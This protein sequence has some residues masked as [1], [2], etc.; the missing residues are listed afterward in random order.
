VRTI[1]RG[2]IGPALIVAALQFVVEIV[3]PIPWIGQPFRQQFTVGFV[4]MM[5]SQTT[6]LIGAAAYAGFLR[7]RSRASLSGCAVGGAAVGLLANFASQAAKSVLLGLGVIIMMDGAAT[8]V[9]LFV[10]FLSCLLAGVGG[11]VLGEVGGGVVGLFVPVAKQE[12]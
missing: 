8:M 6:L 5:L 4:A 2:A 10:L 12:N 9:L 1:T 11:L 3:L 7:R